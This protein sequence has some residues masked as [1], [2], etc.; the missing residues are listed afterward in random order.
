MKRHSKYLLILVLLNLVSCSTSQVCK[1][2]KKYVKKIDSSKPYWIEGTYCISSVI[3]Y[4]GI[5]NKVII[6]VFDRV[7]GN[8]VEE[9]TIFFNDLKVTIKSGKVEAVLPD[10]IYN[11]GITTL[12][13][14]PFSIKEFVL[15]DNILVEINCYLGSSLQF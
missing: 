2:S 14:L 12:N 4:N 8:M 15:N 3:K 6:K 13:S 11:I 10:G 1:E 5:D 7:T 9:G